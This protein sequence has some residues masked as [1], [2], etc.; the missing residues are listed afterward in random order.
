MEWGALYTPV[1][2][3][4]SAVSFVFSPSSDVGLLGVRCWLSPL[5]RLLISIPA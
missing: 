3:D 2:V 1:S 4:K 5:V